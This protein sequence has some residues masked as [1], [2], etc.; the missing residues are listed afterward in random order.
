MGERRPPA[1]RQLPLSL[2]HRAAMT[3]ADFLVGAANAQAI[4]MVDRW[5][6]WPAP[7]VLVAGPVGSGKSH[8]VEIWR[9]ISGGEIVAA[10]ELSDASVVPLVAS[11][12]V[13]IED[14]HIGPIDEPAL[15]HLLNLATERK[16]P[17]LLTSRVWATTL[18]IRLADLASRLRA[19][20]PVEL[21][22]PDDDLLRRVLVKLFAD[23]QLAVDPSVVDY[24]VVR[25]ERSLQAANALVDA[26]DHDALAAGVPIG[27]RLAAAALARVFD[28]R[29]EDV[30]D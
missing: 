2:P 29:P 24:I 9:E 5:P 25:M 7:V 4:D 1:A 3:R 8:I 27:R 17:V 13:A 10:A 18:P 30:D 14:L 16:A 6:E 11:G 28:R 12:A 22:E 19:A 26:L 20:R 21:S 15:F 23:R